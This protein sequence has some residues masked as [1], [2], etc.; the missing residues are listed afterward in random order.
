MLVFS[1]VLGAGILA[2]SAAQVL[3]GLLTIGQIL[4]FVVPFVLLTLIGIALTIILLRNLS[5]ASTLQVAHA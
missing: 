3:A 5:E 1:W 4:G 2:L